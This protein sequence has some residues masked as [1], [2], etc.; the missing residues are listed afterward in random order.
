MA[1]E[2]S[3][4]EDKIKDV[5]AQVKLLSSDTKGLDGL[6]GAGQAIGGAFQASQGAMALFGAESEEKLTKRLK[7]LSLSKGG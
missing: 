1:Q 4:M 5:D 2:A 3:Q 6:V 7:T